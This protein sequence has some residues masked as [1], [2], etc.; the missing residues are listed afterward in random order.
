MSHDKLTDGE[1]VRAVLG[2]D[3]QAFGVLVDRHLSAVVA[4]VGRI[5]CNRA[6]VEDLAQ[7]TFVR[8]FGRLGQY[9]QEHSFRNWLLK[10]ATNLSL[11][12]LQARKRERGRYLRLAETRGE[13][14][15]EVDEGP[16]LPSPREWQYWLSKLDESQ[17]AAIVLF[18]FHEMSY[19]EVA[20]ALDAPIN[21][22]RTYLH[23]GRKRLRELMSVRPLPESEPCSAVI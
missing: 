1:L 11:N 6:D 7:D 23:R 14:V 5:V 8:A 3:R 20:E 10:I 13:A 9:G 22:V 12:H 18:H 15:A 2:G 4:V 16:E 21:T 19:A 17:R